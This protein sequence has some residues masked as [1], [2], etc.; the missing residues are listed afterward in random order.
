MRGRFRARPY[1]AATAHG[2]SPVPRA[3]GDSTVSDSHPTPTLPPL[4]P[5]DEGRQPDHPLDSLQA[6][7]DQAGTPDPGRWGD[8]L[9][10]DQARRWQEGRPLPVEAYLGR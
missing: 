3:G 10:A 5:G 4:P 9:R 2:A 1:A 8:V 6:L 7:L